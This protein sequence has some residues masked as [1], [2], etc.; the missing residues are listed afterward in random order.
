MLK[1]KCA[2]PSL[3]PTCLTR[4]RSTLW[5][6]P[7]GV[8]RRFSRVELGVLAR[9]GVL[10]ARSP[11]NANGAL[12]GR[13]DIRHKLR[14][15]RAAHT[16]SPLSHTRETRRAALGLAPSPGARRTPRTRDGDR[17]ELCADATAD[18]TVTVD[19]RLWV[20]GHRPRVSGVVSIVQRSE[21][22]TCVSVCAPTCTCARIDL[23]YTASAFYSTYQI[24]ARTRRKLVHPRLVRRIVES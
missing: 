5:S 2:P 15:A 12:G 11:D 18:R 4:T 19:H 24:D 22:D 9:C 6:A 1:G 3:S 23:V 21:L 17:C 14:L 7:R 20:N 8:W 13:C 16:G 10:P